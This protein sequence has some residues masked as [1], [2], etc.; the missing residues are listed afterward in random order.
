MAKKD[1]VEK[2]VKAVKPVKDDIP[3]SLKVEAPKIE[4]K[5]EGAE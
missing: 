5:Q 3:S 1:V 2:I 4:I